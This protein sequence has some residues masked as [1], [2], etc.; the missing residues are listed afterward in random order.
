M[1][2]YGTTPVTQGSYVPRYNVKIDGVKATYEVALP[3]L[4]KSDVSVRIED[5]HLVISTDKQHDRSGYQVAS[6]TGYPLVAMFWIGEAQVTGAKMANG[7]L[8]VNLSTQR[9]VTQVDVT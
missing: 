3:G 2:Y 8:T 9:N 5:Q 6:A 7:L 4:D 1:Q